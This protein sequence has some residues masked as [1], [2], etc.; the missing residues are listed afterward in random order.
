MIFFG[1]R[2]APGLPGSLR[3]LILN[4][5]RPPFL[6]RS[7]CLGLFFFACVFVFALCFGGF[8]ALILQVRSPRCLNP[9]VAAGGREA[10]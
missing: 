1:L 8:D 5:A 7:R 10:I 3:T 6:K 4:D 2:A 9:W